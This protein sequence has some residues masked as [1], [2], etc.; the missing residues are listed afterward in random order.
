MNLEDIDGTYGYCSDQAA[1]EIRSRL[2]PYEKSKIHFIDNGNYHYSS[3]FRMEMIREE[4]D[5]IVFDNHTDMQPSGLGPVLSCGSWIL[6]SL[7]D[8]NIHLNKVYLIGPSTE[9]YDKIDVDIGLKDKI[10]FISRELSLQ[11]ENSFLD[12][13]YADKLG[14]LPAFISIDKDILSEEELKTNW[15]QGIMSSEIMCKWL[16]FIKEN[17]NICGIDICGEPDICEAEVEIKKS[18]EINYKLEKL[19]KER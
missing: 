18:A 19:F 8:K 1:E 9:D 14:I 17:V 7:K 3:K 12:M 10:V 6:D 4:F 15:N 13:Q 11:P 16:T 2:C 5:L